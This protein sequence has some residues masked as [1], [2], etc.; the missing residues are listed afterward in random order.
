M[1]TCCI[2]KSKSTVSYK[3][4]D[5]KQ[6]TYIHNGSIDV[7]DVSGLEA[8]ENNYSASYPGNILT[9]Y[10]FTLNSPSNAPANLYILPGSYWDDNLVVGSYSAGY[11]DPNNPY[12]GSPIYC[13]NASQFNCSIANTIVGSCLVYLNLRWQVNCQ[14]KIYDADSKLLHS[15]SG[16]CPIKYTVACDDQCPDG[17]ERIPTIEYPGYKC[18][19][20]CPPE[21]CCECD[22]G[23]VICCYGSQGQVL[24]TI[25]K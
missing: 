2:G 16:Q 5:G 6:D 15:D 12:N 20:K 8:V 13:G 10:N 17:Q 11:Q 18:R 19:E 14:I 4:G 24:K 21:T 23:D 25:P 7:L 3:F 22:C 1:T 9:T